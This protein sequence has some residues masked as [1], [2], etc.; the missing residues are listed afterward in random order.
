LFAGKRQDDELRVWVAGCASGEE[1]Y[2]IA[3]LLCEHAARIDNARR[4]QIFATDLDDEA[5][6]DARDGLYP[7]MI[8]ADVSPERLREFFVRDHGRYRVRKEIREKVL[9]AAHNLLRD[10]PFSRCDLIS[11]R[12]LLIYLNGEAQKAVFDIFHFAL[13]SG[14]MLLLG[15]AENHGQAQ[16]LFSPVDAKHRIFM[17]R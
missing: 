11:C 6:A 17:R 12:N 13:R 1:A 4:I 15:G 9:F 5:I 7:S 10:A 16:S 8:E 3:M 2:S 14:G